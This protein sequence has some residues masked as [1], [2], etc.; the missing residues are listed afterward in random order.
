MNIR[1]ILWLLILFTI[2]MNHA[3]GQSQIVRILEDSWLSPFPPKGNIDQMRVWT[4]SWSMGDNVLFYPGQY[5]LLLECDDAGRLARIDGVEFQDGNLLFQFLLEHISPEEVRWKKIGQGSE[6]KGKL[7]LQLQDGLLQKLDN[8]ENGELLDELDYT[9]KNGAL[10]KKE[11]K[12][13]GRPTSTAAF[14]SGKVSEVIHYDSIGQINRRQTVSYSGDSATIRF[15]AGEQHMEYSDKLEVCK[16]DQDGN[17]VQL[18]N[19]RMPGN[20]LAYII[21]RDI[22]YKNEAVRRMLPKLGLGNWFSVAFPPGIFFLDLNEDGTYDIGLL[23]LIKDHG[24]YQIEGD[25]LQLQSM[26]SE[27]KAVY[28]ITEQRTM[29]NLSIVEDPD[30]MMLSVVLG[31][32]FGMDINSVRRLPEEQYRERMQLLLKFFYE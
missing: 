25:L 1:S 16:K 27:R 32:M 8:Y 14:E 6:I 19:W 10:I 12:Y 13:K 3:S 29:V 7:I 4:W 26:F 24:R 5:F 23:G 21:I 28:R 18:K 22:A 9:Y 20:N 11:N 17:W 15:Y 30:Q 31:D 2:V